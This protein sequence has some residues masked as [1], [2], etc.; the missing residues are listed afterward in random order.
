MK[1]INFHVFRAKRYGF[2]SF[3]IKNA[4]VAFGMVRSLYTFQSIILPGH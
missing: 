1:H 4:V 3:S 2:V